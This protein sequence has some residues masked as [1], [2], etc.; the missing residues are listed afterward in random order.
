MVL[1]AGAA[2]VPQASQHRTELPME[3]R[4]EHHQELVVLSDFEIADRFIFLY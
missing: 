4:D 1:D 3:K 2:G